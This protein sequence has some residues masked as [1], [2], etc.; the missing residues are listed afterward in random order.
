M[1]DGRGFTVDPEAELVEKGKLG[2]MGMKERAY[3]LGGNL[4]ILSTPGGGTTIRLSLP[5]RP[6]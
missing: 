2:L 3:L 4:K 5:R 6:P 1:D